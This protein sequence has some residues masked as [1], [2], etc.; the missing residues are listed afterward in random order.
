MPMAVMAF[1]GMGSSLRRP[2][3][4]WEIIRLSMDVYTYIRG[5]GAVPDSVEE[6]TAYVRERFTQILNFKGDPGIP[7]D[8]LDPLIDSVADKL[9]NAVPSSS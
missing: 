7:D 4:V 8:A 3:R 6:R 5:G 2:Q 1:T 9:A